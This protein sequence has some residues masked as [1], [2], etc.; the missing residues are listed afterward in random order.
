MADSDTDS[1]HFERYVPGERK[2]TRC[3]AD[4]D[5]YCTWSGCPQLRD[6]EPNATGRHCPHDKDNNELC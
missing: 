2:F 3:R 4:G 5:G 1:P 6:N